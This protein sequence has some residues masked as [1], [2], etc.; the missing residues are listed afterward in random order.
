MSK[1]RSSMQIKHKKARRHVKAKCRVELKERKSIKEA[2]SQVREKLAAVGMECQVL[3]E[4]T[5]LM[6]QRSASTQLRLSLMFN[7]IKAR[8]DGDFDKAAH[9]TILL[10]EIIATD[11]M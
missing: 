8:E 9:I 3:Q 1:A 6:I 11:D 10:R 4:E 5:K 7:I 2:Q